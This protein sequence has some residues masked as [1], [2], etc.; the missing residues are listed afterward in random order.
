MIAS[1]KLV[2]LISFFAF[3][4]QSLFFFSDKT[5]ELMAIPLVLILGG[6]AAYLLS[7]NASDQDSDFQINVFFWAF[8]IRLMMG[9]VFYGWDLTA[10]FGDE[11]ASGYMLGWVFAERWYNLGI[12][13]FITDLGTVFFDKQNIGQGIIWGIPMYI[14]GGPSRMIVSVINSF[15]GALLVIVVF[16]IARRVFESNTA[17]IAAIL[18]TF[19]ASIIL[20]SAGTSKE[21]L[22]ILFEW[23]LLYVLIRNPKGLSGRDGLLAIPAFLALFITRFYALY[24]VS[25]AFVFRMLTAGGKHLVRNAIFGAIVIGSVMVLLNAGGAIT[26]DFDRLERQN[27]RIEAWRDIV[28]QQTGTGVEIYSEYESRSVAVPIATIYFFLA[29]FPWEVFSGSAR[30][31]FGA[32]ENLLIICILLVGFPAIKIFFKDKFFEMAPIFVFC[33]LYAGFHIWGLANVGLAWRHK[34]TVMPLLFMLA[35]VGLTQ[36]KAGWQMIKGSLAGKTKPLAIT[37]PT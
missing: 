15:S 33:G 13:G 21:M 36:R 37:R 31:G 2:F 30:N 10:L 24:M 6:S 1:G 26:R 28:A 35:A 19:W 14:V 34:Q 23:T 20:L 32:I 5:D 18:I 11:D 7:R 3:L 16:R 29:P 9:V 12:D 17:K 8:S 25:A 4:V 22:V 27:Q